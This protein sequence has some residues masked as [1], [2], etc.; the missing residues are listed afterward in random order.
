M[1]EGSSI[2]QNCLVSLPPIGLVVHLAVTSALHL[3]GVTYDN[4]FLPY[5]DVIL[6]YHDVIVSHETVHI[7]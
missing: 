7:Y 6:T 1:S 3:I 5:D 4:V 2:G